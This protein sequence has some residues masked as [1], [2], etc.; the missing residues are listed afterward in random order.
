MNQKDVLSFR[1]YVPPLELQNQFADFVKQI[2]KLKFEMEKGLKKL[3]E[4]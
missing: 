2:D 3:E 4:Y 1:L